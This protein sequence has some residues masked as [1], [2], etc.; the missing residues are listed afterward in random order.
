MTNRSL[1]V[2]A[3]MGACAVVQLNFR[4]DSPEDDHMVEV[5]LATEF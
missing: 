4:S 5:Q 1:V 3:A 2:S